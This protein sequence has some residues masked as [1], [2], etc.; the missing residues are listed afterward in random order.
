MLI[1]DEFL[2][3]EKVVDLDCP[4]FFLIDMG[5]LEADTKLIESNVEIIPPKEVKEQYVNGVFQKADKVK[6]KGIYDSF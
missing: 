4:C 6:E 1:I 3:A 2:L 5:S